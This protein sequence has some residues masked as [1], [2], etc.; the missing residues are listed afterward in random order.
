MIGKVIC[1]T[2]DAV[3]GGLD[4]CTY[5]KKKLSREMDGTGLLML[6]VF[7]PVCICGTCYHLIHLGP[8]MFTSIQRRGNTPLPDVP[9]ITTSVGGYLGAPLH[10]RPGFFSDRMCMTSL[11]D[12]MKMWAVS[13]S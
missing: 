2:T 5:C 4:Q 1:A 12:F 6:N 9:N 3:L 11:S 8:P 13:L 10:I 7:E